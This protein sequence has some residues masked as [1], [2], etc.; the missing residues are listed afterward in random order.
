MPPANSGHFEDFLADQLKNC[1]AAPNRLQAGG[2]AA[3]GGA[4]PVRN[5][6]LVSRLNYARFD[7][8]LVYS[9]TPIDHM[10]S[11]LESLPRNL[12]TRLQT[13]YEATS[14]TP[15][16]QSQQKQHEQTGRR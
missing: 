15:M 4:R 10:A 12:A 14:G 1:V 16:Q 13:L 9:I 6:L 5:A 7:Q 8:N 11:L 2:I 3:A